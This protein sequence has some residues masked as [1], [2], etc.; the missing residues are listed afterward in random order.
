MSVLQDLEPRD[1]FGFFEEIAGIPHGSG[2]T[3]AI[4]D[5][6]VDF[7]RKRNLKHLQDESGNVIIWKPASKG[8]EET[9]PV[10][11]QGHLDMVLQQAEDSALDMEREGLKLGVK[12]DDIDRKSVV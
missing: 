10:I 2:N 6:C 1:V 5:Y 7:A 12:G 3:K 11:L 9:A 8:H 4:S